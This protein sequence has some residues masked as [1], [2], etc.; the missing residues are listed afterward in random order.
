MTPDERKLLQKLDQMILNASDEELKKIQK[1][2]IQTQM[3]G[4]SFYDTM[5]NSKFLPNQ[6][7]KNKA[8]ENRK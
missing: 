3:N 2:D 4:L 8:R 6:S 7:I 1:V 5:I